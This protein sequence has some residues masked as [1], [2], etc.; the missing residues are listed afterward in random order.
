MVK[1]II[2]TGWKD[3]WGFMKS[4]FVSKGGI[5]KEKLHLYL[6]EYVCRYNH[7]NDSDKDKIKRI[8]TL[9]EREV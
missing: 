2:S 3:S 1:E 6:G 8:I 5:R 4:K 9:L 7:G